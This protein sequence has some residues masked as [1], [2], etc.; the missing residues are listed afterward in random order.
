M[1]KNFTH[2]FGFA[3][4]IDIFFDNKVMIPYIY[5][6]M[7]QKITDKVEIEKSRL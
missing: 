5:K 7:Q 4:R 3:S 1:P 6:L 2:E